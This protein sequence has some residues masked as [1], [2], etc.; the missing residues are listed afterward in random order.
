MASRD[1][2][3]PSVEE[4]AEVSEQFRR[5]MS[6]LAA[7]VVMVTCHVDGKPWGLTVSA[8]CSVS[9]DPPLLLVSLGAG[10][11]SA[12]AIGESGVFGVSLLGEELI[13]VARFGA[14]RG[15]AKFL[16]QFTRDG[17]HRCASPVVERALAHVDCTV[18]ETV[19]AGD[20]VVYLGAVERVLGREGDAP[21][22]YYARS[23]HRLS[24]ITDLHVVPAADETVDSLLHDYPVPRTFSRGV[25]LGL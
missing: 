20:H 4:T 24:E 7:G 25:R 10:T 18:T 17:D 11:T 2:S 14:S 9:M 13:G 8:C 1:A 19:A 22:V 23:Y 15:Q 21:L 5:A 12:R 3:C 6:R 16:E